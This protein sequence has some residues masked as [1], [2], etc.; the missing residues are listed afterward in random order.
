M[1]RTESLTDRA[2]WFH[3]PH[4]QKNFTERANTD[5]EAWLVYVEWHKAA[6]DP[7]SV[8]PSDCRTQIAELLAK[9]R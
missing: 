7:A 1:N 8:T 2:A 9:R 5:R 6:S 4:R 3:A